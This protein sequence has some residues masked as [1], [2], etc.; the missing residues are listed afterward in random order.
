MMHFESV[1]FDLDGVITKTAL[2]HSKAWKT[3][4]DEYLWQ[5]AKRTGIPFVPFSHETDYLA[6]VDGKPRYK[7]VESFLVSRG[8][9]LPFGD[10]SDPPDAETICGLGNRKNQL[11]NRMVD[12]E[13]VEVYPSTIEFIRELQALGIKT[14]VASSSKNCKPVLV[15]AGIDTFFPVRVDGLVSAELG[16]AGKPEPDIF[17]TACRQMG[18]IPER[19]VVVEDAISGVEAGIR[20]GFGLVLGIA[21]EKN[22]KELKTAGAHWVVSD[23]AETGGAKGI[24]QWFASRLSSI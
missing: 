19:S 16:L 24:D 20:G 8:I 21:R 10:P 2:V 23:L 3:M 6:Y 1:I 15:A 4:F 17:T 18:C 11:F 5:H 13:G 7:G 22:E 12:T 9:I 14:A